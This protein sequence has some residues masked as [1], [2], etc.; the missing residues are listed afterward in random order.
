MLKN[1]I[2]ILVIALL[3]A[4]PIYSEEASSAVADSVVQTAESV[5]NDDINQADLV[6][7]NESSMQEDV[8]DASQTPYKQP[9]SKKKIVMKF[10]LAMVG[11]CVS[12]FVIYFGLTVYNRLRDGYVSADNNQDMIPEGD[13]SLNTP[14]NLS[15]AVK[16]FVEKT[17]WTA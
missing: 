7:E 9:V 1:K 11:V 16:T 12:S 17:E 8:F 6:N 4:L 2:V 5:S 13:K 3:F 15:E 14:Q 10:L